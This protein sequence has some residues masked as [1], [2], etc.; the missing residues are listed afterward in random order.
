MK[1]FS[2]KNSRDEFVKRLQQ[3]YLDELYLAKKISEA[4]EKTRYKQYR[5]KLLTLAQDDE[6]HADIIKQMIVHLKGTPPGKSSIKE[7]A[8]NKTFFEILNESLQLD[9]DEY[10]DSY[11]R[12]YEAEDE[13]LTNFLPVIDK[14]RNEK[15]EHRQILLSILQTLNPY[16]V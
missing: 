10:Y 1:L 2:R 6:S 8:G 5:E 4:A 3:D 12:L 13:G 15:A 16:Q 7:T 11:Q 14:M 9:R